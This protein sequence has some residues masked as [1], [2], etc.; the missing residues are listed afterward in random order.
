M[1]K[2]AY[3]LDPSDPDYRKKLIRRINNLSRKNQSVR[4]EKIEDRLVQLRLKL[5]DDYSSPFPDISPEKRFTTDLFAGETGLP[6]INAKELTTAH[7]ASGVLFHGALIVRGLYSSE[8]VDYLMGQAD[9]IVDT[10]GGRRRQDPQS[11]YILREVHRNSG[12]LKL[13]RDYIGDEA[14]M[15]YERNIL[16][17]QHSA[18]GLGWHQDVN[19]FQGKSF[20]L[21]CWAAVTPCGGKKRGLA[22]IPKRNSKAFGWDLDKKGSAPLKYG[23]DL[24]DSVVA[25]LEKEHPI[26]VPDLDPGDAV[27][28]D[29]MTLH[30]TYASRM[31]DEKQVVTI[32]WFL[33]HSK[34]PKQFTSIGF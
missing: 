4:D 13:V 29:E 16:R 22:F 20:A 1:T 8:T 31:G 19:F 11:A 24:K 32:T 21:N 33:H 3:I 17:T 14:V 28:F 5:A 27:I 10:Y 9:H 30:A 23:N 26:V 6:E 12:L 15:M 18:F 34:M 2:S 25:K 7:L